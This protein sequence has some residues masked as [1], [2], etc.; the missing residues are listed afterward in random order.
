MAYD[1]SKDKLVKHYGV[2]KMN[3]TT[4]LEVGVWQYN[5]GEPKVRVTKHTQNGS[6]IYREA[7]VKTTVAEWDEIVKLIQTEIETT[8]QSQDSQTS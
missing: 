5:G 1:Q 7:I 2:I 4:N 6:N 3:E 8:L